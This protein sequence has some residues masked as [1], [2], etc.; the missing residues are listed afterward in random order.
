MVKNIAKRFL[1]PLVFG[2]FILGCIQVYFERVSHGQFQ[3]SLI[4]FIPHY[5]EGW[6]GFGGN[7]AWY[8]LHLWYLILLFIFTTAML[9]FFIIGSKVLQRPFFQKLTGSYVFLFLFS[10][11]VQ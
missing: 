1:M 7:F 4:Q 2:C 6:Y 3:G 8:G 5:F 9:P 11:A 10:L